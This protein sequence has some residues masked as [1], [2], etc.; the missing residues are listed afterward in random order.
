MVMQLDLYTLG[1]VGLVIAVTIAT[2]FTLL[3]LV[4]RGLPALHIWAAAFWTATLGVIVLNTLANWSAP[5]AMIIGNGLISG[6]NALM[7][8]GL[9]VHVQVRMPLRYPLALVAL[10]VLGQSYLGIAGAGHPAVDITFAIHS[11]I[12]D[13]WMIWLL[14]ARSPVELRKSCSFTAAVLLIDLC[15]YLWRLS[16]ITQAGHLAT[17]LTQGPLATLG[18]IMGALSALL[19]STAFT[20]MLAERLMLD[21]REQARTDGLTGLLDHTAVL[22]DGSRMLTQCRRQHR[23]CSVLMM[24]LDYFKTINDTW[25]HATGDA[26]LIHVVRLIRQSVLPADALFA[27]YGGE[28]FVIV[29][30]DRSA[31]EATAVAERVRLKVS[32]SPVPH[33]PSPIRVTASIGVASDDGENGFNAIVGRADDALYA[34]KHR[35]RDCWVCQSTDASQRHSATTA[36]TSVYGQP[37]TATG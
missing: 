20:L 32:G 2:S 18:Y 22:E 26:V 8:I 14:L 23:P 19:L 21:L 4:L 30:P 10:Y 17:S 36:V 31:D 16:A 11:L 12:W 3:G 7:L 9:C 37:G 5:T 25:G 15:F 24:D 33:Q 27:R 28:E 34:A 6:A 35:G 13:A 1:V 29:L